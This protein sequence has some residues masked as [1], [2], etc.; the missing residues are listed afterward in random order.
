MMPL[1]MLLGKKEVDVTEI[2]YIH[3]IWCGGRTRILDLRVMCCLFYRVNSE[4]Q[5][6]IM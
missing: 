2:R 5:S 6:E 4:K 3:L 1:S